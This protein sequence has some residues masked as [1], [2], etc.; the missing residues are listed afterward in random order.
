MAQF[1]AGGLDSD[2]D[3]VAFVERRGFHHDDAAGFEGPD[4]HL[5]SLDAG[6]RS[7]PPL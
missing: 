7:A 2:P 5:I 3:I 1:N 4:K 6:P